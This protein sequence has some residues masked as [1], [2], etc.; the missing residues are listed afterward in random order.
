MTNVVGCPPEEVKIGMTVEVVFEDLAGIYAA[1]VSP[2][3]I[4]PDELK[5]LSR[6][7]R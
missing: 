5:K 7:A 1:E 2:G 3:E 4:S 6:Q